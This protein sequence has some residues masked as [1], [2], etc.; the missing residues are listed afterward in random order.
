MKERLLS[1]INEIRGNNNQSAIA[2]LRPEMSLRTDI[3]FDSLSLAALTVMIED[4]FDVDVFEDGIVDSIE[5]ILKK[6]E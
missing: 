1:I 6:L 3:G 2:E 4:E 5:Q